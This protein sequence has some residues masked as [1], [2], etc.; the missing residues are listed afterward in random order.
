[1]SDDHSA[2]PLLNR[3]IHEPARLA[4]LTVLSSCEAADFVFLQNATGLS[5]GNLSV[6][7]SNLEQS[8]LILI[9]K[10]FVDKR[11]RTTARLS[12]LGVSEIEEYWK[13]MEAIRE[14]MAGRDTRRHTRIGPAIPLSVKFSQV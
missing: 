13:T 10:E 5:R 3:L 12:K 2:M 9:T 14:R 6:Q 11:P 7:L 8:G 1:M 4:I